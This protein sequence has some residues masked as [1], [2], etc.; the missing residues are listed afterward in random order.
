MAWGMM[1]LERG[2]TVLR[3]NGTDLGTESDLRYT[4]HLIAFDVTFLNKQMH[5]LITN[6]SRRI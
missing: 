3:G 2:M 4:K 5:L 1:R 6:K